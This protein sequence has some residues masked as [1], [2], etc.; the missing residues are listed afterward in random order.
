MAKIQPNSSYK[1]LAENRTQ[2]TLFFLH[3]GGGGG[4]GGERWATE[5]NLEDLE[6]ETTHK[7]GSGP[8]VFVFGVVALIRG[9]VQDIPP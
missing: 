4:G 3:P 2:V 7:V 9:F 1:D 6:Q 8:H 5:D